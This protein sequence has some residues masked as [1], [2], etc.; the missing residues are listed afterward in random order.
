[1]NLQNLIYP[2]F[3]AVVDVNGNPVY[4]EATMRAYGQRSSHGHARLIAVAE[5]MGF[6]DAIDD[7]IANHAIAAAVAA[8]APLGINVSAFTIQSAPEDYLATMRHGRRLRGGLVIELTETV[9]PDRMDLL[10]RFLEEARRQ[11]ARIAVDDYGTGHFEP[12]DI[13]AIRPDYVKLALPRVH[14]AMTNALARRW[15][16]EAIAL[17]DRIG[18]QAIAEGIEN[19]A[20]FRFTGQLGIRLFQGFL[21]GTPS[22]LLPRAS[23]PSSLPPLYQPISSSLQ[24]ALALNS[25]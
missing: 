20:M 21:W 8:S 17:C 5:E 7:V 11:R 15:L 2:V 6:M 1:L 13:L 22:H 14:S 23:A 3:H 18:A 12:A 9:Q 24:N 10:D 25:R 4:H 19:E 16:V